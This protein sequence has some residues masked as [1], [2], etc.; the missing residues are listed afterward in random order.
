M[1]FA[2]QKAVITGASS[3]IG[4]AIAM[5]LARQ[6][7]ALWV[8]GRSRARLEQS[9]CAAA[10]QAQSISAIEADLGTSE[11]A[12][13]AADELARQL[14]GVD[15]LVHCAGAISLGPIERA[16]VE[17]LDEQYQ[18]NLRSPFVLTQ[19]LLPQLRKSQGQVVFVNSTAGL[20][21]NANAAQYSATKHGLKALADSLRDEENRYGVRVLSVFCG[22]TN[23]PMQRAITGWE[24]KEFLPE[25]LMQ[26]EDVAASLLQA[27]A[28]PRTAELTELSLRPFRKYPA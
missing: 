5:D 20:R 9:L 14:D 18:V 6:G 11:G 27:L 15:I 13:A 22:R 24:G 4:Q 8:L 28:L 25:Y 10:A 23:S 12:S 19:A 26:P 21:A 1:H 2:G 17:Q 16:P 7:A 3:G